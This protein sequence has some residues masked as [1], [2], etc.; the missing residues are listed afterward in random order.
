MNKWS[1][2]FILGSL[3]TGAATCVI[4]TVIALYGVP[5]SL[6]VGPECK[7]M[8]TRGELVDA[9]KKADDSNRA[10]LL[11]LGGGDCT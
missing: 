10:L 3:C 5:F 11:K 4:L 7:Q 2:G 6:C 9:V 8:A 1:Q